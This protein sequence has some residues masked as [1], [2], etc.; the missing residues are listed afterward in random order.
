[1]V[2]AALNAALNAVVEAALNV[3]IEA[4]V[5]AARAGEQGRGFAVVAGEVRRLAQRSATATKETKALIDASVASVE[6]GRQQALNAGK[7]MEEIVSSAGRVSGIMT[8]IVSA[9]QE[10][11]S[12]I[13][14]VNQAIAQMDQATPQNA[15][16][17]EQAAA[18]ASLQDQ[19]SGLLQLVVRS[20]L[21]DR[22]A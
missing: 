13:A 12:G 14:Q 4:T 11:S 7:T 18:A 16:L 22:P 3:A 1:M 6:E 10:Q 19:A 15:A 5:E 21:A 9:S 17:V 2:G 8:G 20:K